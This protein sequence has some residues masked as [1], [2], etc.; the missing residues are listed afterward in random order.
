MVDMVNSVMRLKNKMKI[1]VIVPSFNQAEFISET[2]DSIIT[3]S[4]KN[5]EL[6]VVDGGSTDG[7]INI[8][9]SYKGFIS[10]LF[11]EPDSGQANAINKGLKVATGDL[12]AWQ[13]SDDIYLPGAFESVAR[14]ASLEHNYKK[15]LFVGGFYL[16]N[17]KGVILDTVQP[18]TP[19]NISLR[20]EG[21]NLGNQAAF[22]RR[23]VHKSI[24]YLEESL[25][26]EFDY[27]WFLRLTNHFEGI[28]LF[29]HLG[30]YRLHPETKTSKNPQMFGYERSKILDGRSCSRLLIIQIKLRKMMLL[31]AGLGPRDFGRL[32][33]RKLKRFYRSR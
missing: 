9:Q 10:T 32:V 15:Q 5:F 8:L 13:N 7:T 26:Y 4:H 23:E 31:M 1:S 2:L 29:E 19:S 22:W 18:V 25:H 21:M 17:S 28:A 14:V 11:V 16:I 33:I 30:S 6:I 12:V 3:Q 24:G 27:E 20:A